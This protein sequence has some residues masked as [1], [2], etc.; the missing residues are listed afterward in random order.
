MI[1]PPFCLMKVSNSCELEQFL[2]LYHTATRMFSLSSIFCGQPIPSCVR[3]SPTSRIHWVGAWPDPAV[4]RTHI[5]R[6]PERSL[7]HWDTHN[8]QAP[9]SP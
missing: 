9:I 6:S 4:H 3:L 2:Q 7:G 5:P 1:V 8:L